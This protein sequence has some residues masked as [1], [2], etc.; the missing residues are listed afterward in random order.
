[1]QLLETLKGMCSHICV[2]LN[3]NRDLG[4]QNLII[5]G[6]A[7]EVVHGLRKLGRCYPLKLL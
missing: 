6:D 7:L 3:L 4:F 5:E 2:S 1:V